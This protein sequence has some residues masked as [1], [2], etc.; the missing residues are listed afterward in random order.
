[1]KS[2]KILFF[3]L[4][5]T[6]I[7][8]LTQ[9][10]SMRSVGINSMRPAEITF[11]S[12][13][14]S[15][16]LV[17]R[18]KF[19]SNAVNIIEGV[20]TGEMPGADKAAAQEALGALQQTLMQSPRFKV[21]RAAE[22]LKGNSV[23][24]AFPDALPWNVIEGLCA[25][26]NTEA[27][28]AL[29]IFD[30]NFLVTKGQRMKKQQVEQNGVKKEIEVPEYYAEGLATVKIGIRLYDPKA[31]SIVDQQLFTKTKTWQAVGNS[32]LDAL[33]KLVQKTQATQEVGRMA[34]SD[35]AYKIAPMPVRISRQYYSK[36]KKSEQVAAGAR[37]AEVNDWQGA[38]T[39]WQ[40][41]M[42]GASQKD[43]ARLSYNIAV[44]NEVLGNTEDAKKWASRSYVDYGNKDAKSY[45]YMIE[46]RL[47][48]EE[49]SDR[50][51][52]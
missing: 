3:L 6:A 13:V 11:P 29:E 51:M 38:M 24:Q 26:Y 40:N 28:V 1:M 7:L 15:L 21:I 14:N 39:T 25:Q 44:A 41:A 31:K 32:I 47:R 23:T 19:E 35:Y 8:M 45:L 43:A 18:T 16:L 30:S 9:C 2:K 5:T 27:V 33:A 22:T 17:D 52:K 42:N 49:L 10:S 50:Q 48:D 12:Y 34:G 4:G 37:R 36:G 20:L 46:N